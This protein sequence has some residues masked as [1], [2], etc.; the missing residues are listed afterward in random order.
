ML[1]QTQTVSGRPIEFGV[2][3]VTCPCHPIAHSSQSSIAF[4]V[5]ESASPSKRR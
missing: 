1:P 3:S 2:G 4:I 5:T